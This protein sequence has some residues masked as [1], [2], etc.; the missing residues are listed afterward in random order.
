VLNKIQE[1]EEYIGMSRS[2]KS[3]SVSVKKRKGDNSSPSEDMMDLSRGGRHHSSPP[4]KV[5]DIMVDMKS[6]HADV[7]H[8]H[9]IFRDCDEDKDGKLNFDEFKKA[10]DSID[11]SLSKDEII[12][13]FEEVN[14]DNMALIGFDE[15]LK[16]CM[17]PNV[18]LHAM[19]HSGMKDNIG[20][21]SI[22]P[23][24]SRGLFFEEDMYVKNMPGVSKMAMVKSQLLSMELYEARIASLQRFV[25]MTVLFHQIGSRV[26]SFFSRIS[27]G[28]WSYRMDR[29][30]SIMRVASTASPVSGA[31]V[32]KQA[33]ALR[34][35][36]TLD[37]AAHVIASAWFR[38]RS[39][40]VKSLIESDL[41]YRKTMLDH[42]ALKDAIV[43]SESLDMQE[44]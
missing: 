30:H 17:V 8:L 10:Y 14:M 23:M 3:L 43:T 39:H 7:M 36:T 19:R 15:F 11:P 35:I 44:T 13:L 22:K 29:T 16:L 42:K 40:K 18:K 2:Q 33:E 38:Y 20:M 12:N 37:R 26:Q 34:L 27:F 32:R 25:S 1:E 4:M 24:T 41:V 5:S 31:Y 21:K 9:E 28:Y 6:E